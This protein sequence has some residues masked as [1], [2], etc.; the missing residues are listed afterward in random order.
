MR[1]LSVN[2]PGSARALAPDVFMSLCG[3][4]S[5]RGA[6]LGRGSWWRVLLP[7]PGRVLGG[8]GVLLMHWVLPA[9]VGLHQLTSPRYKFNFIADVVEKIAPAVVHIELFLRC[10]RPSPC[11][12]PPLPAGAQTRP[13][14]SPGGAETRAGL[15]SGGPLSDSWPLCALG[16]DAP[17]LTLTAWPG[18]TENSLASPQL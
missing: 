8:G 9:S 16:K 10:V 2:H 3:S 12:A 17:S 15:A 14:S 1:K 4:V 11:Q 7:P 6:E 18:E 13:D 5:P